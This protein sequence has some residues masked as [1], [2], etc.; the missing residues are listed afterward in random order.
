[1]AESV[2]GALGP[3]R[4]PASSTALRYRVTSDG[5]WADGSES[6]WSTCH[7]RAALGTLASYS[8]WYVG[9]TR[10]IWTSDPGQKEVAARWFCLT[11]VTQIGSP[12]HQRG[13]ST[14]LR[15]LREK[16]PSAE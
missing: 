8:L 3:K 6:H 2:P 15:S 14:E 7:T 12:P 16:L 9:L 11:A 13:S 1:M 5:A 10:L 4:W